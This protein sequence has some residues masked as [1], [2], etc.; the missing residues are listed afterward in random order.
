MVVQD[1][2]RVAA[3]DPGI[4]VDERAGQ[5]GDRMQQGMLG[6]DGDLVGLHDAD[7]RGDDDLALGPDL[8]PGP[9]QPNLPGI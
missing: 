1:V 9:P 2:V 6:R 4:G 3:L 7:V 8:V 5:P